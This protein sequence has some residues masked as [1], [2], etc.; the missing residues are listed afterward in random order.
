MWLAEGVQRAA[1]SLHEAGLEA[2]LFDGTADTPGVKRFVYESRPASALRVS[3]EPWHSPPGGI[4]K[5]DVLNVAGRQWQVICIP[6]AQYIA[7]HHTWVPLM[8]LLV[9]FAL[10]SLLVG[11]VAVLVSQNV[12]VARQV[13]ERTAALRRSNE[14]LEEFAYVASHDLQEPLRAVAGY[15]Q[16]LS[17]RY[18]GRIDSDA[19]EFIKFAVDGATRMKTLINDLLAYSRVSTHGQPFAPTDLN[20]ALA[21]ARDN[22][23]AAIE[24]SG[25]VVTSDRLPVVPADSTQMVQLLQNLLGNA[26]K[27]RSQQP[28]VVHISVEEQPDHW[29]LKV[30]DNG[31]GIDPQFAERIFVIFQRLHTRDEYPGTG[32]GLAICQ[33]I[34]VRHGGRIGVE[35]QPGAGATF[36][37]TLAKHG[38]ARP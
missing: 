31:I 20:E 22:L 6:S 34:V 13:A 14:Q 4:R 8:S 24:E 2:V 9:G 16:L 27:Y 1:R 15:C 38:E 5:E 25:A 23:R 28:P 29:L 30:R 11:L 17:R 19:D 3:T 21:R 33:Q 7:A 36:W 35:S 37:C 10:G 12:L 18:Q 26:I 32:V